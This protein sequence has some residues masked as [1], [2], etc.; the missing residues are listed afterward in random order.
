V[1]GWAGGVVGSWDIVVGGV[2]FIGG[3]VGGG[4]RGGGGVGGGGVGGGGGCGWGGGKNK[5]LVLL[6][7]VGLGV[8]G[9]VC[10]FGGVWCGFWVCLWGFFSCSGGGGKIKAVGGGWVVVGV[11]G[12]GG[13]EGGLGGGGVWGIKGGGGFFSNTPFLSFFFFI[14]YPFYCPTPTNP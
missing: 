4:E 14:L 8:L 9:A 5:K 13:W 1:V 12:L 10:F 7:P 2:F 11:L 3:K 6:F